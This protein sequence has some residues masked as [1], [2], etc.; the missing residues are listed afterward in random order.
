MS[1]PGEA[2]LRTVST[3]ADDF[4]WILRVA[5]LAV[6]RYSFQYFLT[7]SSLTAILRATQP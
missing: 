3:M 4:A 7:V 2:S 5:S 1:S 6:E